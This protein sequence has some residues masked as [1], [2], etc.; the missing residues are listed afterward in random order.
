M[1]G[2]TEA[3]DSKKKVLILNYALHISGVSRTLINFANSLVEHGYDVTVRLFEN[4]FTL[5]K[6]LDDRVKCSLLLREWR[7]FGVRI[8][9]KCDFI[10]CLKNYYLVCSLFY[11]IGL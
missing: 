5:A 9:G 11:N 2:S 6:E 8:W 10:I 3:M 1:W 7:L 4:D